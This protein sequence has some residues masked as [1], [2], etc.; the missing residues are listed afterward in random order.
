M[1]RLSDALNVPMP[2]LPEST[3]DDLMQLDQS[4]ISIIRPEDLQSSD[5]FESPV[6]E[7]LE[8]AMFY[9]DITDLTHVVPGLK[10]LVFTSEFNDTTARV[11]E[12]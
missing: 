11:Y 10:K 8:T 5:T 1:K 12:A 6:W 9:E 2:N 7:D 3:G 4:T